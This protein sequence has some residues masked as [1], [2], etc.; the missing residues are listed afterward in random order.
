MVLYSSPF[1]VASLVDAGFVA[2]T[3]EKAQLIIDK[4]P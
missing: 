3:L 1:P 4:A 2:V